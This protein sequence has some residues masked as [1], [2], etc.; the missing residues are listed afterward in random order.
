[1]MICPRR[2]ESAH[3]PVSASDNANVADPGIVA[4]NGTILA[5]TLMVKTGAEWDELRNNKETLTNVLETIGYPQS[6]SYGASS[7]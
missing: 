5:G 7:L 3:I 6:N 4:L 2:N 1:M